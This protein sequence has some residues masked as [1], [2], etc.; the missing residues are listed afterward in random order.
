M[1]SGKISPKT[2]EQGAA[3]AVWAAVSSDLDG[4]GG[5]YLE[6]CSIGE[7]NEDP[8]VTTGYCSWALDPVAAAR[9]WE[10]SEELVGERFLLL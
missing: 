4:K 10:K 9:L 8:Q 3:T 6:D 7:L 1:I 5:L 2:V